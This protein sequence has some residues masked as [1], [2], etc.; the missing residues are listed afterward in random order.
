MA[1]KVIAMQ[2]KLAAVLARVS[3]GEQLDVSAVCL[4]LGIS[5]QTFY[6]YAKRFDA[7]GIEGLLERSRRPSATPTQTSAA[8]EDVIVGWRKRLIE[9]G[10]DAGAGSI[11]HR[12]DRAGQDPPSVRTVHRVLVRRGLVTPQP[13]KRPRSSYRRF[14]Y[15]RTNDCWQI[16]ATECPLADGTKAVVFHLVDDCSRKSLRSLAAPA[17]TAEA[18]NRCVSEAITA[19]GVPAMFLSDNGAAFS[20]R[21][22]GGEAQLE[23]VL[24]A[25]GVRVVTS[26]P[27]HPQTCGKNER[28][29][30]TFKQWLARQPQP[31]TLAALQ[32]CADTFDHLY[33]S[34]RPHSALQGATP[35]EA[36]ANRERCPAPT[37][38]ADPRT[39]IT[40]VVVAHNGAVPIGG[41]RQVQVGRQWAGAPV[42]T[43]ITG[44]HVRILYKRQLVRDLIIDPTRI[45]QPLGTSHGGR[46]RLPRLM[47]TMS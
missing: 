7:E 17:E 31:G 34:Q 39:R 27:F 36:W 14:E 2:V 24:R 44:D 12:M 37:A 15:P 38:P 13:A 47:S 33:N 4:E 42:T 5:R 45:Y 46:R 40:E 30:Q 8:V 21:H 16:D 19:H 43:I 28:L 22:R 23:R 20:A 35:D 26:S 11:W 25:L 1:M 32:A 6:K 10:W 41:R 18:A 3:Q 9:E 29:H